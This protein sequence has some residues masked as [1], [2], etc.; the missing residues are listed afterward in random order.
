MK[1]STLA[2]I[3][4]A[5]LILTACGGGGDGSGSTGGATE[6][7]LLEKW[8][9]YENG[10]PT[11]DMTPEQISALAQAVSGQSTHVVYAHGN[12][13]HALPITPDVVDGDSD[14]ETMFASVMNHNGVPVAEARGSAS[15]GGPQVDGDIISYRDN[16]LSYVGTLDYTIFRVSYTRTCV[17]NAQG[18]NPHNAYV[19]EGGLG[20]Y[21]AT[22][23]TGLGS[24]T[25]TGVM[26]GME[27]PDFGTPEYA[28][29]V[30]EQPDVFLG[31]AQIRIDDFSAPDVDVS[32]TNIHNV[33]EGTPQ[34]AM[35]WEDL[36]VENGLFGELGE[37]DSLGDHDEYIVGMFTGPRHQEVTGSFGRDG[38]AGAFGASRQ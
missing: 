19:S 13:I 17:V 38:I 26:V 1:H 33:T 31:D 18:C 23:P 14:S 7:S 16:T 25:W 27:S 21:S 28:A 34:P 22:N 5:A 9:R 15:G 30:R 36:S 35:T 3:A 4:A 8:Q 37:P 6:L 24:A 29:L 12:E 10:S 11:L 32:F 20:A 2:G